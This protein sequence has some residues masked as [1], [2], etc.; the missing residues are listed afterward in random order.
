ML[1]LG[2]GSRKS[3]SSHLYFRSR[4]LSFVRPNSA[5][6]SWA[7]TELLGVFEFKRSP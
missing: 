7:T 1:E 3:G 5:K 2:S 6:L 4:F